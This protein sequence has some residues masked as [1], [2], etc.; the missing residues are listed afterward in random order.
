MPKPDRSNAVNNAE[1][2]SSGPPELSAEAIHAWARVLLDVAAIDVGENTS[3][4]TDRGKRNKRS[5][6]RKVGENKR[7]SHKTFPGKSSNG[8]RRAS[9]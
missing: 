9:S 5:N 8:R 4:S 1:W 6:S 2:D 3:V 7:G